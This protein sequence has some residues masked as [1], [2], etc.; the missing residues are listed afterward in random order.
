MQELFENIFNQANLSAV[1]FNSNKQLQ[2][3]NSKVCEIWGLNP[4]TINNDLTIVEFFEILREKQVY[5]EKDDFKQFCSSLLSYFNGLNKNL[6]HNLIL[7]NGKNFEEN[8]I[9]FN[10]GLIIIW[11][12]TTK[13]W[14]ATYN[15]NSYKNLYYRIVERLA[16]PTIIVGSNGLVENFNSLFGR[17][18]NLPLDFLS[19]YPHIADLIS[20]IDDIPKENDTTAYLTGLFLSRREF[21]YFLTLNSNLTVEINGFPLPNGNNF[22]IFKHD[23]STNSNLNLETIT[24]DVKNLQ[25]SMILELEQIINTP[26]NTIIGFADMLQQNYLGELQPRQKDYI[27]KIITQAEFI[28]SELEHKIELTFYNNIDNI[29]INEIDI[30]E[31]IVSVMQQIKNKLNSKNIK[32]NFNLKASTHNVN[33]NLKILTKLLTLILFYII[34]QNNHN[35]SLEIEIKNPKLEITIKDNCK[36]PLFSAAELSAR[37]DISLITRSIELLN[38]TYKVLSGNRAFRTL[39]ISFN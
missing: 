29:E 26:I 14:E 34:E 12:D 18:F 10:G 13:L 32:L 1:Y 24:S 9:P 21:S 5:P 23:L 3:Y 33:S 4:L 27:N 31:V 35:A 6:I 2:L 22:I 19:T 20:E 15:L 38:G 16:I 28:K 30:N 37:Y 7:S 25:N 36:L 39:V 11:E 8:I 17:L